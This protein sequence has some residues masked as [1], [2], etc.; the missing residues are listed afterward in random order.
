[1]TRLACQYAIIRFL[2]YAET[3]EFANVGIVLACPEAGFLDARLMPTKK[4]GRITGFFEQLDK[5][6]Y[7][8]TLNYLD[9]E[10]QRV[11]QMVCVARRDDA[12]VLV[13]RMFLGLTQ[14]REA[15]LRFSETRAVLADDPVLTM[16]KL[17]ARFVERDF[18]NKQYHDKL[19]E[20]GVRE[21]LVRANLR[22]YFKPAEVGSESLHIQVPFVHMRDEK[23]THAIKPLD[24]GKDEPNQVYEHGGHWLERIRR[25]GKHE[26]LPNAM[27][28]AVKRPA[29]ADTA[30]RK[31]AD[32]I[33]GDL[34]EEG[35]VVTEATNA[36]EIVKFAAGVRT[37]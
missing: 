12:G 15:L 31:A 16:E 2:P 8:D 27:L 13:K 1:M 20:R 17:F 6:I 28:F 26:L 14:P 32:E 29:L 10:L 37:H 30:V 19:L 36:A 35:V 11:R 3:G 33:I 25:L 24:L 22:E 18:A 23:P 5:Q 9:D 21:V 34:R 7:R 4:T